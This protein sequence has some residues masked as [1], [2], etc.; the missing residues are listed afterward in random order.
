MEVLTVEPAEIHEVGF[1]AYGV[2]ATVRADT[3]EL[4]EQAQRVFPPG[5][6]AVEPLPESAQFALLNTGSGAYDVEAMG[7]TASQATEL[8]VALGVLDT[9]LR[10]HVALNSTEYLFVHA[11][12]VAVDGRAIAIPGASFSGKTT[13]VGELIRQ[14]AEYLS[15][16]YALLDEN[17]L[18][19]PYPKP[20]SIRTGGIDQTDHDVA[21]WGG[22][23]AEG[24]VRLGLVVVA[25]YRPG[26]AWA[27]R[28]L[29]GGEAL[30][31]MLAN[32]IPSKERPER[33][34]A[35]L[36]GAL[37]RT[38]VLEGERGEASEMVG[39]LLEVVRHKPE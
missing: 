12:V 2:N 36:K 28:R 24:P 13:L 34:L 11:G 32:T 14:G 26:R 16:E 33:V 7:I 37:Q 3:A 25:Q 19:H 20:L 21:A 9:Q 31:A 35:L 1:S 5:W 4:L 22:V 10:M 23:V 30:L 18:V 17:G 15:D 6:R 8:E 29:S 39:S 38:V 27:P